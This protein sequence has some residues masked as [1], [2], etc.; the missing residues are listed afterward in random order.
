[1]DLTQ[2]LLA[3]ETELFKHFIKV[4]KMLNLEYVYDE[5]NYLWIKGK[6]NICLTSHVDTVDYDYSEYFKFGKYSDLMVH[7]PKTKLTR[8]PKEIKI[9]RGIVRA[10]RDGKPEVLGGDDRNG[11]WV[12]EQMLYQAYI[13]KIEAPS[14]LLFNGEECGGVGVDK[15]V[16]S[17][18]NMSSIDLILAIDCA[19]A[20]SFVWYGS[21]RS[22]DKWIESFGWHNYGRGVFSDITIIGDYINIPSVNLDA[23]Y[24]HQHSTNEYTDLEMLNLTRN[25]VLRMLTEGYIPTKEVTTEYMLCEDWEDHMMNC[26]SVHGCYYDD[27]EGCPVVNNFIEQIGPCEICTTPKRDWDNDTKWENYN[28][29]H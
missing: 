6:S 2:A 25:K 1:V 5:D 17:K 29:K 7:T 23:G 22:A 10:Y 12:I 19:H 15:F 3:T 28:F 24:K 11:V 27:N 9:E 13:G 18:P 14:V 26:C 16:K 8:S 4:A 21:N 20:N